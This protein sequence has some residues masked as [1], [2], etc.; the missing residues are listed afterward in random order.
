MR[1]GI[2]GSRDYENKSKIKEFIFKLREKY[3][4][5]LVIVSGGCLDGADKYAKKYSLEFG[6]KYEEY[7]PSHFRYNSHCA[8]PDTEYNKPYNV[9]NYFDRNKQIAKFSDMIVSFIPLDVE[10]KGSMHTLKEAKNLNKKTL[11]IT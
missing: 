10:S 5:E 4:N 8:L 2:V 6:I 3:E 9:K 7:P 1:I 11:I